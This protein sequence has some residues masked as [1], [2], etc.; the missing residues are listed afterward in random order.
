MTDLLELGT[1]EKVLPKGIHMCP[2]VTYE[3]SYHLPFKS[4]ANVKFFSKMCQSLTY[5]FDLDR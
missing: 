1:K 2:F 5:D 4:M 3:S